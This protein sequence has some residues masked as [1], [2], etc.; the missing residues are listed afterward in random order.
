MP[1]TDDKMLDS[2]PSQIPL[3]QQKAMEYASDLMTFKPLRPLFQI[4][5]YNWKPILLTSIVIAMKM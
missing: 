1:L 2:Q 5:A 4:T 3:G